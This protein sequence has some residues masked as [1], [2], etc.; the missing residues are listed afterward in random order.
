[1]L[2]FINHAILPIKGA[3]GVRTDMHRRQ[4]L[5]PITSWSTRATIRAQTPSSQ[6]S[7]SSSSSGNS[8]DDDEVFGANQVYGMQMPNLS[9]EDREYLNEATSDQDFMRR[10]QR[11]ARRMDQQRKR[12]SDLSKRQTA[13]DY[14]ESLSRVSKRDVNP[15]PP[16]LQTESRRSPRAPLSPP[17]VSSPT[18]MSS[19]SSTSSPSSMPSQPPMYSAPQAESAPVPGEESIEDVEVRIAKINQELVSAMGSDEQVQT[20][21]N[22]KEIKEYSPSE[23]A[24]GVA[25]VEALQKKM[26]E[27]IGDKAPDASSISA[28]SSRMKKPSTQDEDAGVVDKQIAYLEGYLANLKREAEAEAIAAALAQKE[29]E[30]EE[31]NIEDDPQAVEAARNKALEMIEK[32]NKHAIQVRD[33]PEL[34]KGPTYEGLENTPGEM[35]AGEK[36]AAFEELRRRAMQ[37]R[38]PSTQFS[39]PFNVTLP[40]KRENKVSFDNDGDVPT[41]DESEFDSFDG[42]SMDKKLLIEEIEME[43][44]SY[45]EEAHRL[46]RNHE[47]RMNTLLSRLMANITET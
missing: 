18:S 8:E 26:Q 22:S 5:A 15:Q 7:S 27:E 19:S 4:R 9:A 6:L 29:E 23:L 44:K 10:M 21:T 13:D 25:Q 12:E 34:S 43:M 14:I 32:V 47:S 28:L 3:N 40:D 36:K 45:T 20:P 17:A 42:V 30:E 39:D 33:E 35:S 24:E 11:I 1:M 31:K 38:E 37:Q 46:L 2:T 41:G 16:S